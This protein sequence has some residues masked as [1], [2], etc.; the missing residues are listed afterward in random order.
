MGTVASYLNQ[1]SYKT[2]EC[3]NSRYFSGILECY[4]FQLN[5]EV[6]TSIVIF[7]TINNFFF[8]FKSQFTEIYCLGGQCSNFQ[9]HCCYT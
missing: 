5:A 9:T 4:L 2:S 3:K 8:F 7:W 6:E 1:G